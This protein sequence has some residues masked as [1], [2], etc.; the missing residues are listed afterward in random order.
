MRKVGFQY[1]YGVIEQI[2]DLLRNTE[3]RQQTREKSLP[4]EYMFSEK[5]IGYLLYELVGIAEIPTN[6]YDIEYLNEFYE[7]FKQ[8]YPQLSFKV[9]DLFEEGWL[10]RSIDEWGFG[11]SRYEYK[12]VDTCDDQRNE[13]ILTFV[14]A[15]AELPY[16]DMLFLKID[17][18]NEAYKD[19]L[20][21][22][23]LSTAWLIEEKILHKTDNG[24]LVLDSYSHVWGE[25]GPGVLGKQLKNCV[26][27]GPFEGSERWF[28]LC[29]CLCRHFIPQI[30]EEE[31]GFVYDSCLEYLERDTSTWEQEEC[32]LHKRRQIASNRLDVTDAVT[33]PQKGVERQFFFRA[34]Y[35][36]W[37]R[38]ENTHTKRNLCMG[39]CVNNYSRIGKEERQ[40]FQKI[41]QKP[42]Y[43]IS[44]FHLHLWENVECLADCLEDPNLFFSAACQ[45][46][47][48]LHQ[49]TGKEKTLAEH[50]QKILG[51][52]LWDVLYNGV[53]QTERLWIEQLGE[54]LI[55]LYHESGIHRTHV[56]NAGAAVYQELYADLLKHYQTD[57]VPAGEIEE[58]LNR[59]LTEQM[60]AR[61]QCYV[62]DVLGVMISLLA[63]RKEE[64][65]TWMIENMYTAFAIWVEKAMNEDILLSTI[66]WSL[67][68]YPAW[69]EVVAYTNDNSFPFLQLVTLK[70]LETHAKEQEKK[71]SILR[72]GKLGIIYLYLLLYYID[73]NVR[74]FTDD[75]RK[76]AQK[77][78]LKIF[79]KLQEKLEVFSGENIRLLGSNVVIARCMEGISYL[80]ECRQQIF[81]KKVA[82]V[83]FQHLIFWID[84]VK[85][86]KIKQQLLKNILYLEKEK[87]VENLISLPSLQ[88]VT[89]KVMDLCRE[90][91]EET[92]SLC[93]EDKEKN[94]KKLLE[95]ADYVY[96][97]LEEELAHKPEYVKKEY[98]DWMES[99]KCQLLLLKNQEDALLKQKNAFYS[100]LVYLNSD[101]LEDLQRAAKI[102]REYYKNGSLA[103][104]MNYM[105]AIARMIC[106]KE[107][108]GE[109]YTQ[110]MEKYS[111]L[112][113]ELKDRLM[114]DQPV[115]VR[116]FYLDQ[117]YLYHELHR[118]DEFWNVYVQ[119]PDFLREDYKCAMYAIDVFCCTDQRERASELVQ[120]LCKIYGCT[121]ELTE[122]QKNIQTGCAPTRKKDQEPNRF[123]SRGVEEQPLTGREVWGMVDRLKRINRN[124]LAEIMLSEHG[125]DIL[126]KIDSMQMTGRS[127]A[128]VLSMLLHAMTELET[129]SAQLLHEHKVSSEDAYNRT[130][131]LLFNQREER[132]VGYRMEEQ[133][134]RG[135]T[136]NVYANGEQGT[137]RRD[138][139]IIRNQLKI[140]LVEG[141]CLKR[142]D[143]QQIQ[144]HIQKLYSYNAENM[145]LA[146]MVIYADSNNVQKLWEGY[147]AYLCQLKRDGKCNIRE[148][149]QLVMLDSAELDCNFKR[150][151][152]TEHYYP[153]ENLTMNVYHIMI[154]VGNKEKIS[155]ALDD[156]K[157]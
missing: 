103:G 88:T 126:T 124:Q 109:P 23:Q 128:H 34:D 25:Y 110:D 123:P 5:P 10:I 83:P 122:K 106:V 94:V 105:I 152:R 56:R 78:F 67:F 91:Q 37:C 52:Y 19:L 100:G 115:Y 44:Y 21:R 86:L 101:K 13:M 62:N 154:D 48:L 146:A 40:L 102:Y 121:P 72:E 27:D 64:E 85:N 82:K 7:Q 157:V 95:F 80:P 49:N 12:R 35:A 15:L 43:Y 87:I 55:Y 153:S 104:T 98:E 28:R 29:Q 51:E 59:Y 32:I 108:N 107:Q 90:I 61:C 84:Y 93:L 118:Y 47:R 142:M 148:I 137:A 69:E 119:M 24:E 58:Q 89:D 136:K 9:E 139:V 74:L 97:I 112:V 96:Q 66:R 45:A 4:D 1:R 155:N 20:K 143:K 147:M 50:R 16:R 73:G 63:L 41:L 138:L 127:E 76:K 6:Y 31:I 144:K 14:Q 149:P 38:L 135:V 151:C 8:D 53:H 11:D 131:K 145:T 81:L 30:S 22:E 150:I 99:A 68:Q 117:L 141:I 18:G 79:F 114:D 71:M 140:A 17:E 133:T 3:V 132:F 70:K 46:L 2:R 92:V 156:Q 130:L 111:R 77:I 116:S 134:Q 57:V 75:A 36:H 54:W 120:Q 65:H 129:Y 125:E 33:I 26:K 42:Y 60:R 39:I 113:S